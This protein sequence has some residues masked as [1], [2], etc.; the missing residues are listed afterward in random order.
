[1][2]VHRLLISGTGRVFVQERET[3]DVH[4]QFGRVRAEVVNAAQ[5]GE[6]IT[7]DSGEQLVIFS[8]HF[9]DRYKRI[10][11]EAQIITFKDAGVILATAGLGSHSRVIEAGSGS[12]ALTVFLAQHCNH[13]FS[14]EKNKE[15]LSVAQENVALFEQDN[16][17]FHHRDIAEGI[18]ET[19]VDAMIL[20]VP[21]PWTAF[22][23]IPGALII[24]GYVVTYV[25]STSQL[26]HIHHHAVELGLYHVRTVEVSERHWMVKEQAVR[27][28]SKNVAFTAFLSFFRYF[29][30]HWPALR[31]KE[32]QRAPMW[33]FPSE[34]LGSFFSEPKQ[35]H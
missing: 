7:T 27:P 28:T 22:P 23:H 35:D 21:E 8:P 24:G 9:I 26:Q 19:G 16:V 32:K 6:V 20:D 29:G 34:G 33:N 2:H 14:Y 13:V 3:A 30:P 31:P 18:V 1:M 12:G 4:T 5:D 11:R 15:H 25:P 17:T 10:R